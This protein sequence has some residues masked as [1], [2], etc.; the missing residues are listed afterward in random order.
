MGGHF[1][2]NI[3]RHVEWVVMA[4]PRI[5]PRM[6]AI[7]KTDETMPMYFPNLSRG[8]RVG[9]ITSTIEYIPEAPIPWNA[10][11]MILFVIVLAKSWTNHAGVCERL[12][13][14]SDH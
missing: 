6:L 3:H 9:A 13:L 1:N 11:S 14:Q 7:A 10:R 2:R 5:G 8:T 12:R 4:P